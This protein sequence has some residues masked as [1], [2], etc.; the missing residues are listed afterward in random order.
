M[1]KHIESFDL[2]TPE[3]AAQMVALGQRLA[4]RMKEVFEVD[5]VAFLFTGGDV[6]HV[7]AHVVPIHDATDI[8]SAQYLVSG[9]ELVW[10]SAHLRVDKLELER[11]RERILPH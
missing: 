6:P 4:R 7:H 8:T 3:L 1:K 2:L 9:G 11:V 5:R 10:D